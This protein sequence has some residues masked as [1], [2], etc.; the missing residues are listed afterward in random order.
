MNITKGEMYVR[1]EGRVSG[2]YFQNT[3]GNV[4][5]PDVAIAWGFN[6]DEAKANAELIKE[7]F[8]VANQTGLSPKQL[9]EQRDMLANAMYDMIVEAA[10][11]AGEPEEKGQQRA[12][13]FL[14]RRNIEL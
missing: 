7:A 8:N 2:G 12:E 4:S 14:K 11:N 3:I 9:L 6:E 13:Y 5:E 10:I 1:P